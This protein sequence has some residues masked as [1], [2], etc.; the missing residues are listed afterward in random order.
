MRPKQPNMKPIV[1]LPQS[2]RN[3]EAGLKLYRRKASKQPTNGIVAA[4]NPRFPLKMASARVAI[5]AKIPTPDASP[6]SPSIKF[7]ALVHAMSHTRLS[8]IDIHKEY[9]C[10]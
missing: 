9:G 2:P 4:A 5:V 3:I 7:T 6:P 8:G 10:P 1:R